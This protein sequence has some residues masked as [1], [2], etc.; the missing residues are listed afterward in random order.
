MIGIGSVV[1]FLA[2]VTDPK[3]FINNSWVTLAQQML[4]LQGFNEVMM[5][6]TFCFGSVALLAGF[7][8]LMLL[9][10]QSYVASGIGSDLSILV[11]E[12]TLYQS[13]TYHISTNSSE[14]I[15]NTRKASGLVG[16]IIQPFFTIISS[17]LILIGILIALMVIDPI[18]PL[19]LLLGFSLVYIFIAVT[20]KKRILSNGVIIA[21][22]SGKI[23]KAIQEG[24]GGIR[25]VLI[26]GLQPVYTKLYR[27]SLVPLQKAGSNNQVLSVMPRFGIEAI[28]LVL[29]S[30][31]TAILVDRGA[32][33]SDTLPMLGALALGAL[34]L[35]PVLQQIYAAYS[36]IRGN[37]ASTLDALKILELP[38][39]RLNISKNSEFLAFKQKIYL[40]NLSFRYTTDGPWIIKDLNLQI[41]KGGRIGLIGATGSGKSTVL[42]IVMGLLQP[43]NGRLLVDDVVIDEVNTAAWQSHIAHVPQH[44]FLADISIAENIAF[45]ESNDQIDM[46]RVRYSAAKAQLDLTIQEWPEKYGTKIG[47]RGV[48]LSGGQRQRLGIARA[49]YKRA[50]VLILDEATSALDDGTEA[51]VMNSIEILDDSI[52]MIIVAHRLTTLKN[53]SAIIEL[54][55]GK[56]NFVG[57]YEQLLSKISAVP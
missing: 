46:E 36:S 9:W 8:R 37:E 18:S 24:L 5:F 52:T 21:V 53:C 2:A 4:N 56:C 13:Y 48:R 44:I 6:V 16:S 1:P 12:K 34:K 19:F 40:S 38:L 42:D 14:I 57:S 47:E 23:T 39:P 35:L 50:D 33:L 7:S 10:A 20:T 43:T 32:G 28:G 30:C 11:Y 17:L 55:D 26:D 31:M 49:L 15:A 54:V 29:V 3:N 25:D 51:L 27:D 45:G 41:P 22:Q